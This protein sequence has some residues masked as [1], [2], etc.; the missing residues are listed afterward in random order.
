MCLNKL[1]CDVLDLDEEAVEGVVHSPNK[2]GTLIEGLGVAFEREF[3]TR[4]GGHL[5]EMLDLKVDVVPCAD[6]TAS[7]EVAS[8]ND[9]RVS[10]ET[11]VSTIQEEFAVPVMRLI[12]ERMIGECCSATV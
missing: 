6:E 2:D 11:V 8:E 10:S 1:G 3:S 7:E 4:F 9:C 12:S 5:L